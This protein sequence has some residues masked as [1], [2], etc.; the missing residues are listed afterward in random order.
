MFGGNRNLEPTRRRGA[1]LNLA[2]SPVPGLELRIEHSL[3]DARFRGGPNEG[4]QIS[5]VAKNNTI[6][7]VDWMP[8]EHL[9]LTMSHQ[10]LADRK[11][12]GDDSGAAA[13]VHGYDRL[14]FAGTFELENVEFTATVGN[15][16]GDDY[17]GYG[18]YSAFSGQSSFYPAPGRSLMFNVRYRL[19]E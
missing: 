6:L 7:G 13:K 8:S 16:L 12:D 5:F 1:T 4:E 11:A 15:L 10:H 19:G 17:D 18:A 2:N 9:R 14:D 3:V